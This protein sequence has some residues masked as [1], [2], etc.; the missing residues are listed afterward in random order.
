MA[1][2]PEGVRAH[3][4]ALSGGPV[5]RKLARWSLLLP[6]IAAYEPELQKLSDQEMRKHSLSLR[7]RAKAGEPLEKLLPEA[8]ALVRE[9]GFRTLN[10]RHFDV[11]MLGGIAMH[12]RSVAEMQ[13]GEGKTLTA[14]LPLYLN[15]LT[16]KGV[17]LAT[18]NDYLARRDAEWM[19][20]IFESLGLS[21]GVIETTMKR[22][23]RARN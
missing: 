9:A 13:T 1:A 11:Q 20:P 23:E 19:R 17:H 5:Q 14:T 12:F 4:Q 6:K 7:Y 10:M 21:V 18:V 8:F 2:I 22:P 15:G 16:G 3:L